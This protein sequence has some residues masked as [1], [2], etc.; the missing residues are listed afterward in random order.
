MPFSLLGSGSSTDAP[1]QGF[2]Y[3]I[4]F[5]RRNCMTTGLLA[6]QSQGCW[7]VVVT[8]RRSF[9]TTSSLPCPPWVIQRSPPISPELPS[10]WIMLRSFCLLACLARVERQVGTHDPTRGCLSWN[11]YKPLFSGV[12]AV[13]T[14]VA[15]HCIRVLMPSMPWSWYSLFMTRLI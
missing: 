5:M 1:L 12:Q 14:S 6:L 8:L 7:A 13:F 3:K 4:P 9:N 11:P 2:R 15:L 10:D